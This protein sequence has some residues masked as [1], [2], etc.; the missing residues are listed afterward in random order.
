MFIIGRLPFLKYDGSNGSIKRPLLYI[1]KSN[2][3]ND[4]VPENLPYTDG[5][6]LKKINL[7]FNIFLSRKLHRKKVFF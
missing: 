4:S 5:L 7:I 1:L 6:S 3:P 2:Y